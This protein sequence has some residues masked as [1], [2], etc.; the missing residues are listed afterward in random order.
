LLIVTGDFDTSIDFGGGLLTSNG[1][2]DAFVLKLDPTG[3][4]VWSL[5]L[6]IPSDAWVEDVAVDPSGDVIVGAYDGDPL[7]DLL[8]RI[9]PAGNILWR[10]AIA[11]G[12]QVFVRVASDASGNIVTGGRL[13]SRSVD[14]GSGPLIKTGVE[15][16]VLLAK[17]A[18]ACF[19]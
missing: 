2:R 12:G 17:F 3:S 5:A 4:H 8:V 16:D 10:K 6:G 11:G 19:P 14:F 15:G 13:L 18:P 1:D 9:D 7:R